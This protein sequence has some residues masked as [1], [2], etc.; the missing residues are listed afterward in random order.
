MHVH[1]SVGIGS[2]FLGYRIEELIGRGGMGVVYRAYDLRLKRTVAL[3]LV[4]PALARHA[5]FR[6]RFARES[7]LVMSLE[8]PNVVPIYDAGD[9]DGHV[10]LAMRLVDGRDLGSLL[11]AEGALEPTRAIAICRQIA[12][13]LDAAHERDL[14]H[15]D[16]KPSNVLVDGSDHVYLADFGLT[17]RL[18]E[19]GGM[20]GEDF[21]LG[22]PAYLAPEQLDGGPV[23]GSADTYALGCVLYE[24]LSGEPVFPRSSRLAVAWAHLEEEPPPVSKRRVGL[25]AAVDAVVGRALAKDREHRFPTCVAVVA[26]AEEALGLKRRSRP[27]R[28]RLVLRGALGLALA[29]AV[30]V[31]A[32]S[33][34]RG[35]PL[36]A[37]ANSLARIDP[38]AKKV[39][40]VIRVGPHPVVVAAAAQR[41]WVYNDGDV[42][43]SEIDT[44]TNSVLRTASIPGLTPAECCSLFA[45]PVL[46]ADPS[47]AWFVNG[48]GF[49]KAWLT[50]IAAYTGK[51]RHYPLA[52]TPTGVAVSHGAVWVVGHQG[53]DYRLLRIDPA[54][55]QITATT[56]FPSNSG[57]TSI[58]YGFHAV[59]VMS[60]STATLYKIDPDSARHAGKVVVSRSRATRPE[61]THY[62]RQVTVRARGTDYYVDP[63]TL[64]LSIN[65]NFGPPGWGEYT[66]IGA[67]WWYS[68]PS[69]T[70]SQQQQADG[71]ITDIPVTDGKTDQPCLTSITTGAK[72]VWVTA[73]AGRSPDGG[74]CV[75]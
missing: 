23:D 35:A 27:A 40:A 72:S 16:V 28:R 44:R 38:A 55:G 17:R 66:G 58:A 13:A 52:L 65:G 21:A 12:A 14:V 29:V 20:N 60:S 74:P 57:I 15:G 71:P 46:A 5:R 22:T 33:L 53:R 59:W 61:M 36:L 67:L 39:T 43:I 49:T 64:T 7:E 11:R 42:S 63:S 54:T 31:I 51:K 75:R 18:D 9:F 34:D 24:C 1:E 37:V 70:V 2:D 10:Y 8:H 26:S 62:L 56:R 4:A 6:E 41:V 73:A 3:K 25:P 68:W 45:G 69:G 47:G 19:E 32:T 48:G 50:H 30:V